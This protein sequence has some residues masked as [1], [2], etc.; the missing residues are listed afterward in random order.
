[1]TLPELKKLS[2][3]ELSTLKKFNSLS[4]HTFMLASIFFLARACSEVNAI[5]LLLAFGCAITAYTFYS[6]VRVL[7]SLQHAPTRA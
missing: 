1:M 4:Y 3:K 7:R 5:V 2:H 6:N